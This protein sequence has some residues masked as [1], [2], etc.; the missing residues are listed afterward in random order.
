[1]DI[2]QDLVD[3]QLGNSDRL[4]SSE[5]NSVVEKLNEVVDVSV[6]RP[7]VG[8]AIVNI[9][10]DLLLSKTNVTPVANK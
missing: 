8:A 6:I 2:I 5:L 7:A 4:T 3:V 9:I 10:A 1:M